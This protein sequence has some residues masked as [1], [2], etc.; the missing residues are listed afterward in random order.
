MSQKIIL[1]GTHYP[2]LTNTLSKY[3]P[4]EIFIDPAEIF[5]DYINSHL[6]KNSSNTIGCE[7]FYVSSSPE[8]FVKNAKIF[9]E[10]NTNVKL[11]LD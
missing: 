10:I 5:V 11:A 8:N 3:A 1:G 6:E 9:Y 4:K 7:E 2:Y